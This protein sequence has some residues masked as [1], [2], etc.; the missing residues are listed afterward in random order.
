MSHTPLMTAPPCLFDGVTTLRAF[1]A[2]DAAAYAAIHRDPHNVTWTGSE[3]DMTAARAAE[4]IETDVANGWASG[5]SLRFAIAEARDGRHAVIGTISLH[6]VFHAAGGGGSAAVGIKMHAD[7]RGHGSALRA[8]ELVCGYAFGTLGLDV[9]HWRATVGNEA[10]RKLAERSG[11]TL[12]AE[13]PGFGHVDGRLADGW[14]F[15]LSARQWHARRDG[16]PA[17]PAAAPDP[18]AALKLDV[19]VPRLTDGTVVLR[20][21]RDAD[22]AQLVCNCT[23]PAAVR[24]TTVPLGYT[25]ED[26]RA[27]IHEITAAGWRSGKVLTFAVA[28]AGTDRL[29]GTVDLQCS[30]PG[31][32]AI[33]ILFGPHAR[34]TG[35]A[36]RAVRLLSE[37]AFAQLNLSFLHWTAIVPNWGSR[38]LAWK[39]GFTLEGQIRGGYNDRGTPADRWILTLAAGDGM[40][41]R[42]PWDGPAP[43]SR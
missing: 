24:W 26:A 22:A 2:D 13:V 25:P 30:H 39:L 32:A 8:V 41:P 17:A 6:D 34:G 7:G 19:V 18:A 10:S 3:A 35:A 33:G 31:A 23:D 21:L 5:T 38:K 9:L 43:A 11:F 12:A 42:E 29:L 1:T 27:F 14:L 28:D 37:Y 4:L 36:E 20:A 15:S 16:A 40:S